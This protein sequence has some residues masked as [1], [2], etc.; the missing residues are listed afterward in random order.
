ME[1]KYKL[2]KGMLV[3]IRDISPTIVD[4]KNEFQNDIEKAY[5]LLTDSKITITEY[6]AVDKY[7]KL[8]KL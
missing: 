6:Y 2:S 7:G 5:K 4:K 8:I 1:K 3:T